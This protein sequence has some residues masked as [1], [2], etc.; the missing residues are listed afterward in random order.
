[1]FGNSRQGCFRANEESGT[2]GSAGGAGSPGGGS[3]TGGSAGQI[4]DAGSNG[5]GDMG[6]GVA[7]DAGTTNGTGGASGQGGTGGSELP[8]GMHSNE[9]LGQDSGIQSGGYYVV[10]KE[11]GGCASVSRAG[12]HRSLWVAM[13]LL[14]GL[15][16]RRHK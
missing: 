7:R 16:R 3:G 15:T 10:K 4:T 8:N 9:P 1:M 11:G 14:V 5:P 13:L 6:R 2:G 12:S